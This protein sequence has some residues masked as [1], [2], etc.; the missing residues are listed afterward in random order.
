MSR[1]NK[2]YNDLEV[3]MKLGCCGGKQET[4]TKPSF[5]N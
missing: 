5:K 3:V 1:M 2:A 4:K